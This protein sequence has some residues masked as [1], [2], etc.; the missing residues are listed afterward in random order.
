MDS[1]RIWKFFQ[2]K[3]KMKKRAVLAK[4]EIQLLTTNESERKLKAKVKNI[5]IIED[6]EIL[7]VLRCSTQY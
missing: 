2:L 5:L 3:V 4:R 6:L 1:G 7:V